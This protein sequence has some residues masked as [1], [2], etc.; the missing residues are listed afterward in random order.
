VDLRSPVVRNPE[1]HSQTV[2]LPVIRVD[3]TPSGCFLVD[4]VVLSGDLTLFEAIRHAVG[5][6]NPV[7]RARSA[8][9]SVD[10]LL[11]GRCGVLLV[12]MGAVST[13]PASLIQQIVEQFPDVVIV[14]AGRRDD[15]SVLANLISDGLVYR[16]MHKPLTPKRAG[17]FVNAAIRSHVERRSGRVTEPLLPIVKELRSRL[18]PG[19]W[20]LATV[21][22]ALL[23][24]LIALVLMP[25]QSGKPTEADRTPAVTPAPAT[26][27][28]SDPVL[29]RARAALAAGRYEAPPGRNAL[30]LFAAVLLARPGDAE[31]RAG[32]RATIDA[33]LAAA[34]RATA[35]GD[36][37][38]ARR[39]SRRVLA[40][41]P[42]NAAARS[43]LARL[44]TP[45]EPPAR[46]SGP[47]PQPQ[48]QPQSQSQSQPTP[49]DRVRPELSPASAEAAPVVRTPVP[50]AP[51][52]GR[53]APPRREEDR[54]LPLRGPVS[55]PSVPTGGPAPVTPVRVS[56]DPLAPRVVNA[57]PPTS[58]STAAAAAQRGSAIIERGPPAPRHA[59][60]GYV[61]DVQRAT[62]AASVREEIP[63]GIANRDLALLSTVEP[64]YPADAFRNRIEGWVEVE[65]TVSEQGTVR[66]VDVVEAN[67]RGIFE[68]A[69]SQAISAWRYRPR[70]VNGQPVPQRTSVTLRFNVDG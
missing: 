40:V 12:D 20:L 36:T 31:A 57:S 42:G 13:Q 39:I 3:E 29:S 14:V 35:A 23:L 26:G 56:P 6:R 45:P 9:E 58:S 52:R 60:A 2:R 67:P 54:A 69:A 24:A 47:Q 27:P 48:S 17:M 22:L 66:D 50:P 28:L 55:L 30:D 1:V 70:V 34:D 18:G 38:E 25:T 11:S 15:E 41:E 43:L 64:V 32:L 61:N 51:D 62:P 7:W 8:E 16:F 10:L 37:D 49:S 68:S 33:L 19:R 59:I 53:S 65:F 4:I 44:E 46:T 21:G 63:T 5:E